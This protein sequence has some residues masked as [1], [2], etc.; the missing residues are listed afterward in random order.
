MSVQ[1]PSG[2]WMPKRTSTE[3]PKSLLPRSGPHEAPKATTRDNRGR[4]NTFSFVYTITYNGENS[5]FN[6]WR[7]NSN[8]HR[9]FAPTTVDY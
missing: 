2:T 5:I 6:V 3:S 7:V 9:R 8:T 1:T 4:V